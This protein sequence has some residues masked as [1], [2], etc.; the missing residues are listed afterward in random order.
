MKAKGPNQEVSNDMPL[1]EVIDVNRDGMNDLVFVDSNSWDLT[2]LYN[3]YKAQDYKADNLCSQPIP[4]KKLAT[5]PFFA[6]ELPFKDSDVSLLINLP[7]KFGQ[8]E[9][10]MFN[11][12][13]RSDKFNPGRVRLAD[14]N[15]D[16]FPD[17]VITAN[18][19]AD[20]DFTLTS[21][22]QS[23][24]KTQVLIN[25]EVQGSSL[26]TFVVTSPNDKAT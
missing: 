5:T 10:N 20:P 25:T 14:I 16:G 18:Y 4:S 15:T 23:F 6:N 9:G 7:K 2:V 19:V 24:S 17:I 8:D 3:Q 22:T 11:G 13:Q 26:R 12:L 1:I 21:S